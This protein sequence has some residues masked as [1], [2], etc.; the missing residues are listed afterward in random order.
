MDI[1]EI[2]NFK[3]GFFET[4][5]KVKRLNRTTLVIYGPVTLTDDISSID[6]Y[7]DK[8]G[9]GYEICTKYYFFRWT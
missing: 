2:Q 8:K 1:L 3:N 6:V 9:K 7:T 4:D 5:L